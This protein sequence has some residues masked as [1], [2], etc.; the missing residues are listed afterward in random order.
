MVI[1][2][3]MSKKLVYLFVLFLSIGVKGQQ[4]VQYSQFVFN[5]FAY[6]PA[7]AGSKECMDV[8]LGYRTQ[9][10]GLEG[11]PRT[12]FGTFHTKIKFKKSRNP[13][14]THGVG[15][16]VE[17]DA[18]GP[19]SRT[20]INLAYAYHFPVARD[21]K[22]S[23]GVFAGLQQ[24]RVDVNKMSLANGNDPAIN[25]S[26]ARYFIPDVAP[27]LFLSHKN[28]FAGYSIKQ[29]VRNKWKILGTDSRNRWHHNFV[30][31]KRFKTNGGVNLVPSAMLKVTGFS[32]PALDINLMA[33]INPYFE[34]GGSW[35]NG[36]AIIG[37]VKFRFL[38]FFTL[39]YS[40]DFT[41]SRMRYGSSNTHEIILGISGCSF[42]ASSYDCPA[43]N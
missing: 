34:L 20:T 33:E 43:F 40:F 41:T 32:A 14:V 12:A 42:N 22:A 31:G 36:D 11:A 28:W 27:G 35:R 15:A 1:F 6:N 37:M 26:G 24:F 7:L 23:V 13:R 2:A 9:W 3:A 29:I 39:G 8:K 30:F 16:L 4:T 21:V 38:N 10:V 25:G 5:Q 17:S 18:I 19:L